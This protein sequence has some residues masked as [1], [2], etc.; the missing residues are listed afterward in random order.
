MHRHT[1][2][3]TLKAEIRGSNPLRPTKLRH[4]KDPWVSPGVFSFS[5]WP[6]CC[7]VA[8]TAWRTELPRF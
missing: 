2:I 7:K 4:E 6:T 8:I 1:N 5:G 3:R